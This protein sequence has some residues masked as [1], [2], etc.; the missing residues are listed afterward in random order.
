MQVGSKVGQNIDAGLQISH[1][2]FGMRIAG[3]KR[4]PSRIKRWFKNVYRYM[5]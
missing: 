3:L 1:A 4:K 5:G 2:D